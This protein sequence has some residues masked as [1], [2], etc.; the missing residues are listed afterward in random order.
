[1]KSE[2]RSR[3]IIEYFNNLGPVWDEHVGNDN[4]RRENIRTVFNMIDLRPGYR[5]L[6]V[7][8]GNGVLLPVIEEKIGAEGAI[9]A[10]DS[11]PSMIERAKQLH[12]AYRN[13][14]YM[15]G[16]IEDISFEPESY[17][18]VLCFAVFPHISNK[19]KALQNFNRL[20]KP[21]GLLYIF[22]LA[23]TAS[24]NSFHS[25]LNSPVRHDLLPEREE[26]TSMIELSGF[27]VKRYIDR[28][29]LNFVESVKC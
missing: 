28:T 11:A 1:M 7:G 12:T 5:V 17:D 29:G 14:E 24:L 10:V 19:V 9:T 15:A 25:S 23:D 20:I 2:I 13:I 22:H 18:A 27:V 21:G 6:D 16:I 26:L 4:E 3:E 8:S